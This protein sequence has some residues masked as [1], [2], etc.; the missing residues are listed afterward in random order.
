MRLRLAAIAF[1]IASL[2][3]GVSWL[4]LQPILVRLMNVLARLAPADG[5]ELKLLAQMR[6]SLPVLLA[7]DLAII[8][9]ICV[10]VLYF[11][12]G[13]GLQATES[14]VEQLGRLELDLP[15]QPSGGPLLS[16]LQQ[17]LSRMAEALR[18]ERGVTQKQLRELESANQSLSRAQT[19]LVAA[20]RLAM[21]GELAA[22]VAHEI[23]NPLAGILGY[24]SLARSRAKGA[25]ELLDCLERTEGEVQRIDQIVRGLLELGRPARGVRGPVELDKI[26]D[27][28][29]RL[30][31]A[32]PDFAKV[33]LALALQPHLVV[34]AEAGPLSQVLLNLLLNAA[35]AQK[36]S[37]AVTVRARADGGQ[38]LLQVEDSGPGLTEEV[39]QNLFRPFFTTKA[40]GKGTGLGLAV[41]QHLVRSMGGQLTAENRPEGGARFTL[42][43][44]KL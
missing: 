12:V 30:V 15:F 38:V 39:Q 9:A 7:L 20:E 13:R 23:G 41:C 10:G 6:A 4:T 11:T 27:A 43:L 42:R 26:V 32:G 40:A 28:S 34:N 16:R 44:D 2:C 18:A 21:V 31:R 22:G 3:V 37:G 33:E 36:G 29:A 24:L 8:G 5:P 25:P 35:Q 14:T 17:A 1:L 19:E